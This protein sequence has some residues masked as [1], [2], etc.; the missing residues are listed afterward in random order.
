MTELEQ[1]ILKDDT[2]I[3]IKLFRLKDAPFQK[4]WEAIGGLRGWQPGHIEDIVQRA[5]T[6]EDVP[7]L[8]R[9]FWQI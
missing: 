6:E 4:Y 7:K 2:A 8:L 3:C 1:R 5:K 9:K